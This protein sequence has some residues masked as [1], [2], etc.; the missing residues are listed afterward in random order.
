MS[1]LLPEPFA[2]LLRPAALAYG[3]GVAH[4]NR[5]FDRGD[6][7][8]QLPEPVISVGNI[9]VGGT[10]KT[11][12]CRYVLKVLEEAGHTPAL[13]MRGYRSQATGSADE[14][15]EYR[16][17]LPDLPLAVGAD[18]VARLSELRKDHAFDCVVLDDGFQH[19]RIARALDLV[20]VDATRPG[21]DDRLLPSGRLRE[22]LTA[23]ARADAIL[24]TRCTGVD[25]Q[26]A[27]RLVR[28][29][30]SPPLAWLE[31]AWD[32]IDVHRQGQPV[33]SAGTAE[34]KGQRVAI[35]FGVGNPEPLKRT[36]EAAGASIV[37][38][39]A[40][41]DHHRYTERDVRALR[42][43]DADVVLVTGKDWVKLRRLPG[44]LGDG[45]VMV[46]RLSIRVVSGEEALRKRI[47]AAVSGA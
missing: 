19:R 4:R 13:A 1:G 18:R 29:A 33:E 16:D 5:R 37:H 3:L 2:T 21:L 11:P 17:V 14:A 43:A 23:L 39:H 41:R 6:G 12:V 20:L 28:Y 8:E 22:P 32:G 10:G 38:V 40:A 30:G 45:P 25:Q 34:L 47:Q 35:S 36:V 31:H 15:D 46:P 7:V 27:D 24:V 44:V 26:L 42:S 9:T